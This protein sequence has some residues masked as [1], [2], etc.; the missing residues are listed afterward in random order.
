V[1]LTVRESGPDR[2]VVTV[3]NATKVVARNV[4]LNDDGDS[5]L[6]F[7]DPE[8]RTLEAGQQVS[9][10]IAALSS[11]AG[12]SLKHLSVTGEYEGGEPFS[13]PLGAL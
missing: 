11:R 9:F 4:S 1:T 7:L 8:P 13:L 6:I 3:R 10:T 12:D 5:P 2:F